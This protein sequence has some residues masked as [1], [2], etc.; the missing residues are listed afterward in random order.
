MATNSGWWNNE[1]D[2]KVVKAIS[3]KKLDEPAVLI[4][5]RF[6]GHLSKAVDKFIIIISKNSQRFLIS[7]CFIVKLNCVGSPAQAVF[8]I[9]LVFIVDLFADA[10]SL[11]FCYR[12]SYLYHDKINVRRIYLVYLFIQ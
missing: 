5:D 4:R 11:V 7:L 10:F 12:Y 3:P 9:S 1:I 2:L 6:P 8:W